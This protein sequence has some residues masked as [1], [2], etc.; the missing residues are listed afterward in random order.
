MSSG[1]WEKQR[2]LE[3]EALR[4]ARKR[5]AC[6]VVVNGLSALRCFDDIEDAG[7][8]PRLAGGLPDLG[9]ETTD[10]EEAVRILRALPYH[11]R[12]VAVWMLRGMHAG[13]VQGEESR[14]LLD[15]GYC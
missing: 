10:E 8:L 6:R 11:L 7:P 1:L 4:R 2:R 15:E 13:Y 3:T 9:P 5:A 14:A 12:Q